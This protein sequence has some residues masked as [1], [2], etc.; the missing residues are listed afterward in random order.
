MS[1]YYVY[2]HYRGPHGD[3]F[4]VGKGKGKRELERGSPT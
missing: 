2:V 1:T 3:P 4:Y